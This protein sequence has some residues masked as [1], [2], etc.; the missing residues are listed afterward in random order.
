MSFVVNA[1]TVIGMAGLITA[2]GV[3][4]GS[5][6]KG[7]QQ[8]DKW[9]GYD[10]KIAEIKD[11]VKATHSETKEEIK[12]L[13]A[14]QYIQTKVLWATLDGLH[15]LGCNG[16]VTEATNELGEYLNKQAHG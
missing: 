11:E 13:K 4:L 9:N 1:N 10:K 3:L 5:L 14:E 6:V 12:A 2:I 15:Q 16:K 7:Y 8:I